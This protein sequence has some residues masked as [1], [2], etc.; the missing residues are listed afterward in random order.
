MWQVALLLLLLLLPLLLLLQAW[1]QT[2]A[3]DHSTQRVSD[4][5]S[6]Q[7]VVYSAS[8]ATADPVAQ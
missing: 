4:D 8:Y 6:V 2:G 7:D 5:R 3:T 1:L